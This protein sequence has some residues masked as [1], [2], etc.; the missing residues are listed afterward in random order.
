[1]LG[2]L[3]TNPTQLLGMLSFSLATLACLLASRRSPDRRVWKTLACANALFL[4]EVILGLRFRALEFARALLRG[5][6]ELPS[7]H[8]TG[9]A[10]AIAAVAAAAM[11]AMLAF[12]RVGGIARPATRVGASLTIA[13]LAL[14][15]I[16]T[17]SLHDIDGFF[18]LGI[19]PVLLVG[20]LWAAAC[21][22]IC[23]AAL[24]RRAECAKR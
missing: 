18:Y 21:A 1:M 5:R 17:V 14:F 23:V 11:V 4:L 19:G 3:G 10:V 12:L 7:L 13:L 24:A 16:E 6:G 9:Q 8:G 20:W 2:R 15:G 22:G